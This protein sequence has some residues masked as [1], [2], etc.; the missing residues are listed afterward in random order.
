[1]SE[2]VSSSAA[3][4][5]F[6]LGGAVDWVDGAQTPSDPQKPGSVS[7]GSRTATGERDIDANG[8]PIPVDRHQTT[9]I[10]GIIPN[11]RAVSGGAVAHPPG[12]KYNFKVA[13]RQSFDY[14]G[15]VFLGITSISAEGL[16]E[17]KTFGKGV[18]G[19]WPY[20]WHGFIDKTDGTYIQAW[21]LPSLL[22]EDTRY[23]ALGDQYSVKKRILHVVD[24]QVITRS[25]SGH[26]TFNFA[27]LGG[28]VL[29][30]YISRFYYPANSADFGTL[31][32]KF[33]FSVARDI[34]FTALREFYPDYVGYKERKRHRKAATQS[35]LDQAAAA[36]A[37]Q[38]QSPA[39]PS[40]P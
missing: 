5:G 20:T 39:P 13:T 21:L 8:N 35:T 26:D 28:K 17:H 34:G 2:S 11:Y 1:M 22:H 38:S 27:G 16:N 32:E 10:G 9:R 19:F 12:W 33:S 24:R 3:Y 7:K 15:F 18:G 40:K 30:Q 36:A 25:Y 4:A 37:G 6:P 31:A 23:Y 29:T 14:S